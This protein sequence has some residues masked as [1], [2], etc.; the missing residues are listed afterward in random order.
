MLIPFSENENALF[1]TVVH[2]IEAQIL[3]TENNFSTNPKLAEQ[4]AN[5]AIRLLNQND[6]VAT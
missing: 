6:P 2:Q 4:H 5:I 3:L 1:L